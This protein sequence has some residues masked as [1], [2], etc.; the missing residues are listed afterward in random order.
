MENLLYFYI[1]ISYLVMI[2]AKTASKQ[3]QFWNILLA[4]IVL[5]IAL[6]RYLA[7]QIQ[8]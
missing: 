8:K 7:V 1:I 4:P 2:G 5:P 3:M 6:G